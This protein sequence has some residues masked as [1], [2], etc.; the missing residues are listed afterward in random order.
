MTEDEVSAIFHQR[1]QESLRAA[2]SI[3]ETNGYDEPVVFLRDAGEALYGDRWQTALARDLEVSDRTVRNWSAFK[4]PIP[5]GVQRD[6]LAL[7]S[8][9]EIEIARVRNGGQKM[10]EHGD[11]PTRIYPDDNS[12]TFAACGYRSSADM[13][14]AIARDWI[15]AGA[16]PALVDVEETLANWDQSADEIEGSGGWGLAGTDEQD[17]L[18]NY[19]R[20]ELKAAV[21]RL[22]DRLAN[23]E[24]E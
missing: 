4:F 1:E 3:F 18:N 14:D 10:L 17:P 23:G 15:G 12:F 24:D 7:L 5:V 9:R 6:I 8:A 22:R 21:E 13:H 2:E 19:D 16:R 20:G 11:Q